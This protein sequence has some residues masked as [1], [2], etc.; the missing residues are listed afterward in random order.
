MSRRGDLAAVTAARLPASDA[1]AMA[2]QLDGALVLV[3]RTPAGR[4]RRRCFLA[5]A[6]AERAAD[7]AR[8]AGHH[9]EVVLCQLVPVRLL[10][11][12]TEQ[13]GRAA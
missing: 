9:A 11:G 12:A 3:V 1:E 2:A 8:A 4:F 7:R 5:V 10:A 13:T 6:S